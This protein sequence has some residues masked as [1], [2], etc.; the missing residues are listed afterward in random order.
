MK[1]NL[2]FRRP[3]RG[4]KPSAIRITLQIDEAR[5]YLDGEDAVLDEVYERI[6]RNIVAWERQAMQYDDE[7][8]F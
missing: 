1:S 7:P 2:I 4:K 8:V 6:E 3:K 5:M